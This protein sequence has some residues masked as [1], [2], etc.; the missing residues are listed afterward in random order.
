MTYLHIKSSST[1]KFICTE[2]GMD[3]KK[4][5]HSN[6]VI[7]VT[8]HFSN[9]HL[10]KLSQNPIGVTIVTNLGFKQPNSPIGNQ[11]EIN[12]KKTRKYAA[13]SSLAPIFPNHPNSHDFPGS[14]RDVVWKFL[15]S[16]RN[17][18]GI[19]SCK[20]MGLHVCLLVNWPKTWR[21]RGT[22]FQPAPFPYGC[23]CKWW[24]PKMDGLQWKTL[25]KWMIWGKTHYFRKHPILSIR[26]FLR[27]NE[28]WER[29]GPK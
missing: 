13:V 9:Y 24:Y 12:G 2:T 3:H 29:T 14:S 11:Y 27:L 25:L 19:T 15:P 22:N 21:I 18:C 1:V 5:P 20:K 26:E 8:Y 17:P 6:E 10:L 16:L 4:M 23:F 28:N 7:Q